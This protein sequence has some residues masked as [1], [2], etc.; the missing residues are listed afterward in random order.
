M[1]LYG[2]LRPCHSLSRGCYPRSRPSRTIL[3]RSL[4]DI[5]YLDAIYVERRGPGF[6]GGQDSKDCAVIGDGFLLLVAFGFL[7]TD[8]AVESQVSKS[9][10]PERPARV[11]GCDRSGPSVCADPG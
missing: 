10:R 2:R 1:V 9:T 5:F 11:P 7:Q 3:T 8:T 4:V 6:A